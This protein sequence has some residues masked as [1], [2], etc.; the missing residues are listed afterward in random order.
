MWQLFESVIDN[1]HLQKLHKIGLVCWMLLLA[2]SSFSKPDTSNINP[3][4]R[5]S[6]LNHSID[7]S[8]W[9]SL[10]H[11]MDIHKSSNKN[12]M[13]Q[14]QKSLL[15][16]NMYLYVFSI[17][18]ALLLLMRL[19][20]DDFFVSLIEGTFSIKKFYLFFQSKKYDSLLAI[21]F[22]YLLNLIC[23]SFITY[24]GLVYYLNRNFNEFDILFLLKILALITLFFVV[25]N[26]IEFIFNWVI[27]TLHIFKAF[28]L[29]NLF[30]ELIGS[31]L[32]LILLLIFIYNQS[33]ST[34]FFS[35]S[36]LFFAI[37]YVVFNTI[38]SYQLIGNVRIPYKLH[39]FLYIC[40]FKILPLLLMVKYILNNVV[41]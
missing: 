37:V 16:N 21:I 22:T 30:V 29:Q 28:F 12:M 6:V 39:F 19:L 31:I 9:S 8:K 32:L 40:A 27:N 41:A 24:V 20:L 11:E 14:K 2:I 15:N 23:I 1:D 17:I 13:I 38:R 18:I 33:L 35:T 5:D 10:I 7:S 3:I 4:F 26:I 36:I 25:K 34:V